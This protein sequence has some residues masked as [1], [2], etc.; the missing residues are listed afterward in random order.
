VLL[1]MARNCWPRSNHDGL[2]CERFECLAWALEGKLGLAML[3][4]FASIEGIFNI[5]KVDS[6]DMIDR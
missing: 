6:N 4:W 1:G 2:W 5:M 3:I